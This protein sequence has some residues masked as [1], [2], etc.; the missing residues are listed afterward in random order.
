MK[1]NITLDFVLSK[2]KNCLQ[3]CKKCGVYKIYHVDNLDAFYIGSA[4]STKK[5]R[6]G[7]LER[8]KKHLKSLQNNNHSSVY[9]QRVAN[10]YG[11]EGL[12]FDILEICDPED[13]IIK[14]QFWLDLLKPFGKKGYNTCKIAGNT[15]GIKIDISINKN[16]KKICKYSLN[17][18][19]IKTYNSLHEA[20][21]ENKVN[22]NGIKDCAKK[23]I[24]QSG[25][26]QWR[27]FNETSE[28][29]IA[30]IKNN[31]VFEIACYYNGELKFIGILKD[32]ILKTKVNKSFIYS[33][34][35]KNKTYSKTGW[36]FR[37]NI[38]CIEKQIK[39]NKKDIYKYQITEDNAV[40]EFYNLKTLC[41][42][43]NVNRRRF[44]KCF[45]SNNEIKFNNLIIKK[46]IL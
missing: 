1:W 24:A 34:I 38:E 3:D 26:F 35:L 32:V 13:C 45:K 39:C 29:N 23:R 7:F 9:L 14:E 10:K 21:N 2:T 12:R 25:M 11:I 33:S 20:A 27:Y 4:S 36:L 42:Y 44:D 46:I 30:S 8:W 16:C 19:F 15:K 22:V 28:K 6:E 5:W 18:K 43:L 41:L 37:K 17:G 40:L 31:R